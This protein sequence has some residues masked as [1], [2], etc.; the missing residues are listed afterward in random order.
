MLY[1]RLQGRR[2][3]DVC[4]CLLRETDLEELPNEIRMT[5]ILKIFLYAYIKLLFDVC[6]KEERSIFLRIF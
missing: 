1:I 5:T 3:C 6:T 2:N 4:W